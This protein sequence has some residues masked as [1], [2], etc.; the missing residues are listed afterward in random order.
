M[1]SRIGDR[2]MSVMPKPGENNFFPQ[3]KTRKVNNR[4]VFASNFLFKIKPSETKKK[5]DQ[6]KEE[7][8]KMQENKLIVPR[9]TLNNNLSEPDSPIPEVD[10]NVP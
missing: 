7:E 2:R 8:E 10:E 6:E 5:L 9:K 4:M 1:K 3:H